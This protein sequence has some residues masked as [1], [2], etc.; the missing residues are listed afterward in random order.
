MEQ[1]HH[2]R[3][4]GKTLYFHRNGHLNAQWY[5]LILTDIFPLQHVLFRFFDMPKYDILVF[6][7]NTAGLLTCATVFPP[8]SRGKMVYFLR[9]LDDKITPAN[10]RKVSFIWM[11]WFLPVTNPEH[12][13]SKDIYNVWG[14]VVI[15]MAHWSLWYLGH[16]AS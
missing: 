12:S 7:M 14:Y 4:A 8:I 11:I 2:G 16:L 15:L 6:R 10:F 5:Q 1:I 9:N 3:R 13:G